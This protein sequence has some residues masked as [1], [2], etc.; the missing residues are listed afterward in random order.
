MTARLYPYQRDGVRFLADRR[1]A[2]LADTMGLGKT[3]QAIAAACE[4]GAKRVL[5]VCPASAR[6]NWERELTRWAPRSFD[7]FSTV[8]YDGVVGADGLRG[9]DW[10]LVILD[11]AH[12][13]K[14][15][16]AKRTR[17]ALKL[18]AQAPRAW[19]LSGTPMP[20]GDPR[21]IY[22][23][24]R[25]LW[26]NTLVDLGL[27]NAEDWFD[28]WCIWRPGVYGPTVMGIRDASALR[29][30]LRGFMLRRTLDDVRLDLPPLR[31]DLQ[32]LD[33]NHDIDR[34][35]EAEGVDTSGDQTAG[36][37]TVRRVLGEYKAPLIAEQIVK[38]LRDKAYARIVVLAYHHSVM[39]ALRNAFEAEGFVVVGFDGRTPPSA[40]QR[41][42]D[43]FQGGEADVFLAQ[44][45]AAG[46]AINLT[47]AN[48]IV[49]VEPSWS[50]EDNFQAIK[51]VHRIG[52][53]NPCRARIFA[54][55]GTLDEAI[56]ATLIRKTRML[57]EALPAEA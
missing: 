13:C 32:L 27:R 1:R 15:P 45:T 8:S 10:D 21:E 37:A 2:Y 42:I 18:A 20:N 40:R 57:A 9:G 51:R 49:L 50:P 23:A 41:A 3:P 6:L 12:Y 54:V 43:T 39:D 5:V 47:A 14:S 26:P 22:P 25:F 24:I 38:E 16:G 19:L 11:E 31:I 56:Q 52:Q 35:L 4:I 7:R 48:E 29:A 36:S 17:R 33:Y 34:L 55:A 44:Q 30:I 53:S 46:V 28:R